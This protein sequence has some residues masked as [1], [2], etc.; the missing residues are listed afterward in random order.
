VFLS[1]KV[2][3]PE[4]FKNNALPTQ[5]PAR[6]PS[7]VLASDSSHENTVDRRSINE[8]CVKVIRHLLRFLKISILGRLTLAVSGSILSAVQQKDLFFWMAASEVTCG[9]FLQGILRFHRLVC[10]FLTEVNK[11]VEGRLTGRTTRIQ[12]TL[13]QSSNCST[14]FKPRAAS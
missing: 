6:K 3:H 5:A 8:I 12:H 9:F 4:P 7:G 2:F 1:C 10:L 13:H 14:L 11:T